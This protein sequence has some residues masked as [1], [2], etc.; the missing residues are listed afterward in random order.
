[1]EKDPGGSTQKSAAWMQ[2][3]K[4]LNERLDQKSLQ[5]HSSNYITVIHNFYLK[6]KD[7]TL[8]GR[9]GRGGGMFN[10]FRFFLSH[11][12]CVKDKEPKL[13]DFLSLGMT[14]N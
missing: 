14:H 8:N 10:P 1:M 9:R 11:F 5:V 6:C 7:L 3:T 2:V 4:E 13:R 12:L